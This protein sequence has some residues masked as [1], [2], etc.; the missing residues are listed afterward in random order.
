MVNQAEGRAQSAKIEADAC[1]Y[2][3]EQEALGNLAIYRADAE[4]KKLQAEAL[5]GGA[6]VVALKFAENIPD[7]LQI[8]GIPVGQNNTSLLDVS[9][10]FGKMFENK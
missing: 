4:G 9:G 3:L 10:V 8:W 5:G 7:K 1:R 2:K 6:N